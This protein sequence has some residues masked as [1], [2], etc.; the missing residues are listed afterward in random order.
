[1]SAGERSFASA[2]AMAEQ[3]AIDIAATLREAVTRR[4]SALIA[5]SGGSSPKRLFAEL[6][7]IEL[8]WPHVTVTQVDERWVPTVH[9]DSNASLIREH[10]L[11]GKA[12]AARFVPMK[13]AAATPAEGQPACEAALHAMGLPF[14]CIL[15]G[16]GEDGHTASLF[17]HTAELATALAGQG[18]LCIATGIPPPPHP[19]HPRM[20]LT[21]AGLL[22]SRRLLLP[23]SGEAK[24]KVLQQAR[25]EGPVEAMPIRALLRQQR[26]PVE[27]WT[28]P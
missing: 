17:P 9:P 8:P 1:M 14:D 22:S 25:E 19:P 6:S 2:A 11:Q 7:R 26:V 24:L 23:L 10:L 28:S 12:A 13:N 21:L 5:V 27:V 20:S 16:M 4:G 15:L 18:P 3:L